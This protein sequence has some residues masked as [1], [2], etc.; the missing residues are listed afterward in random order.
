MASSDVEVNLVTALEELI[1]TTQFI[2]WSRNGTEPKSPYCMVMLLATGNTGGADESLFQDEDNQHYTSNIVSAVRLQFMG[3]SKSTAYPDAERL[4]LLLLSW[5]GRSC[6]YRNGMAI[7]DV[8]GVKRASVVRD[9][10]VYIA[11]TIDLTLHYNNYEDFEQPA[12]E[13]V[14]VEDGLGDT[15]ETIIIEQGG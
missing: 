4:K 9:T 2:L 15:I 3:D 13:T 14:T 10:K 6:F 1:P 12:I 7:S 11:S 8:D 5:N